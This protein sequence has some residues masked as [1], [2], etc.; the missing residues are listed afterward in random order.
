MAIKCGCCGG[1]HESLALVRACCAGQPSAQVAAG[2]PAPPE[3]APA[4]PLQAVPISGPGAAV[5]LPRPAADWAGPDELGRGLLVTPGG[6]VPPP[7]HGAPVLVLDH[8]AAR[9]P[10]AFLTHLRTHLVLPANLYPATLAVMP[11]AF[12]ALAP[13]TLIFTKLDR[14]ASATGIFSHYQFVI[15]N[16][17]D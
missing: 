14:I 13:Q 2:A 11:T 9:Q 16:N 1:E 5:P 7:W 3:Q 15:Q 4:R 17:I 12:A 8:E 6:A 10:H